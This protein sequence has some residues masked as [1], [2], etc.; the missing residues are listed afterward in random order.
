MSDRTFQPMTDHRGRVVIERRP[1][2]ERGRV[3]DHYR[4]RCEYHARKAPPR[5]DGRRASVALTP[6]AMTQ[7][8]EA[9]EWCHATRR[10]MTTFLTLTFDAAT[11]DALEAGETTIQREV[12]RFMDA[13]NV[14]RRRGYYADRRAWGEDLDPRSTGR[15]VASAWPR[16]RVRFRPS[17]D[18]PKPLRHDGPPASQWPRAVGPL[19]YV[20]V[21]EAP[22]N[23]E[24]ERNPHV[25]VLMRWQTSHARFLSWVGALER[26]WG[27]GFAH[28]ERIKEAR[29]AGTYLIKAVGYLTKG[30]RPAEAG[31]QGPIEG[32]RYG[33]SSTARAPQWE[34]AWSR[35]LGVMPR[36]MRHAHRWQR[37]TAAPVRRER[38]ALKDARRAA[39][40]DD[41]RAKLTARIERL[42]AQLRDRP[43]RAGRYTLRTRSLGSLRAFLSWAEGRAG[44]GQGSELLP[45]RRPSKP[46]R[47]GPRP[48]HLGVTL[49]REWCARRHARRQ[50]ERCTEGRAHDLTRWAAMP[51]AAGVHPCR[52]TDPTTPP[53][54]TGAAVICPQGAVRIPPAGAMLPPPGT[55][56][57]H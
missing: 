17:D 56:P 24:G 14:M 28:T 42:R 27:R 3:V 48:P 39:R 35:E 13:A 43:I 11:R 15:H 54:W 31:D 53:P 34:W 40:D 44:P 4:L 57:W 25:H 19:R 1:W 8:A 12:A 22:T 50:I 36:L 52:Y 20:W 51:E 45:R 18:E 38:D 33:I 6:R 37:A 29:A 5:Q 30:G 47:G 26:A 41:A 16:E 2:L 49:A 55:S 32:N 9:V 46:Y 21:A 10:P 7:L 23:E